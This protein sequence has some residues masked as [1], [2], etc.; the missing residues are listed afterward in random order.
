MHA[1]FER[2]PTP[3]AV[4]RESALQHN[5]DLLAAWC[6]AHGL[7][8]MPHVKTTMCRYIVDKQLA[9]GAFGVTVAT[10]RQARTVMAW[11]ERPVMLANQVVDRVGLRWIGEALA[12]G[13]GRRRLICQVDSPESVAALEGVAALGTEPLQVLI[14][15]GHRGGRSG[16][17][18]LAATRR[19]AEQVH[20]SRHLVVAG[21]T[22]FEGTIPRT[23]PE[24]TQAEIDAFLRTMRRAAE[25]LMA[26]GLLDQVPEVLVSAGGSAFF[27]RVAETLAGGW[28]ATPTVR[29]V[30]RSGCYV[31][32]DHGV[33]ERLSPLGSRAATPAG[34]LRPALVVWATV[35]STPEPGMAILTAGKRDVGA[36]S[37][38]PVVVGLPTSPH[39][40]PGDV[41]IVKLHDQHAVARLRDG[42]RLQVGELVALGIS[43]PCTTFDKWREVVIVDDDDNIIQTAAVSL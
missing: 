3:V 32:H 28:P 41:E 9:A 40:A 10:A 13:D 14:E 34:R 19:L 25:E 35:T 26:S 16:V 7:A 42:T 21:V 30:L 8:L 15:L 5:V 22:G 24:R 20:S 4:V 2:Y 29:T 39:A 38:L 17:R 36:D 1:V 43:H 12:A 23:T 37:G 18:D 11:T 6:A 27:D 31:T 33:Y